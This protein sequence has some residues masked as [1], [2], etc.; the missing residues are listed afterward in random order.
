MANWIDWLRLFK[1]TFSSIDIR[2][3][4][5]AFVCFETWREVLIKTASTSRIRIPSSARSIKVKR[6]LN[7]DSGR[8]AYE[9]GLKINGRIAQAFSP[10]KA[11]TSDGYLAYNERGL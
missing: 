1:T 5:C 2:G 4:A 9:S 7:L 3:T 6:D 8:I 11:F 10:V